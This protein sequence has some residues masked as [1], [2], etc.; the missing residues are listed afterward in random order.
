MPKQLN[1][2]K[3]IFYLFI[4]LFAG[5]QSIAQNSK[6]TASVDGILIDGDGSTKYSRRLAIEE[7]GHFMTGRQIYKA[8]GSPGVY[9]SFSTMLGRDCDGAGAELCRIEIDTK[10]NSKRFW[11]GLKEWVAVTGDVLPEYKSPI[12]KTAKQINKDDK[13]SKNT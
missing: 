13:W 2:M 12:L 9:A 3:N 10:D 1:F 6:G 7:T 5:F 8:C 11:Y 4:L